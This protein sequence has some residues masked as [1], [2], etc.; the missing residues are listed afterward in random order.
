MEILLV[1][2]TGFLGYYLRL[3][4]N[5]KYHLDFTFANQFVEN[6]IRYIAGDNYLKD[7]T[8]KKYD[9]V[10]NNVNPLNLTNEQNLRYSEDIVSFSR[11]SNAQLIYISSVSALFEN[12]FSNEYNLKKSITEDIIKAELTLNQYTILRFTQLFDANGL[13]RVSQAGLYYLLK[14]IKNNNPISIF[15]NYDKCFRNYMPIELA[16][17]A[18]E[19]AIFEQLNG[20]F[21]AHFDTFTLS[22]DQLISS[23]VSLNPQ[24]DSSKLITIGNKE[25][26]PYFIDKQSDELITKMKVSENLDYY[27]KKAYLQA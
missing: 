12:K 1:G 6:G 17:K 13:S 16:I 2:G 26:L 9:L 5:S 19:T 10:I 27:F 22:F 14:E 23:L 25:G 4:F 15:S 18:I 24:Y 7:V 3:S 11:W 21:N 8:K 20:I